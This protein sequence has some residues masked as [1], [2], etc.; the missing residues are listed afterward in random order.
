MGYT[1]NARSAYRMRRV[2]LLAVVSGHH[3][4]QRSKANRDCGDG[5]CC[6]AVQGDT[7]YPQPWWRTDQGTGHRN[8]MMPER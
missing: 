7:R 3:R 2:V 6:L 4:A 8:Q 5:R 1:N